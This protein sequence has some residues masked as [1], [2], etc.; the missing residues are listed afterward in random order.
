[1]AVRYR[2]IAEKLRERVNAGEWRPGDTLPRHIDLAEEYRA[3]RN[4]IARAIGVLEDEGLLWAVPRRA[5][6]YARTSAA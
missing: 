3:S 1:M 6:S 5:R 4:V 2:Q